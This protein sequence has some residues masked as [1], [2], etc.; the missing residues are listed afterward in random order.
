[1]RTVPSAIP[2]MVLTLAASASP[3]AAQ[4]EPTPPVVAG[5]DGFVLASASGDYKLQLRAYTH[6]DGRFF[7]SDDE[8]LA[9]D[10]F[11][12]RRVRPMLQGSLGKPFEFRIMPDFAGSATTLQEAYLDVRYTPKAQVRVFV[13]E[14]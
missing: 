7:A 11:L 9:T 6:F 2:V 5:A 3:L 1:M 10:A 13:E 4:D 14:G 8:G 12:L